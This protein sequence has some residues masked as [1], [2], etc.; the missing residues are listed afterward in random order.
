MF[1]YNACSMHEAGGYHLT[2][3]QISG[4]VTE[5]IKL[6]LQQPEI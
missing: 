6:S 3:T 1:E 4:N 2:N 5:N